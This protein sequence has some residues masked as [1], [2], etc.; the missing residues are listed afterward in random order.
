MI[1]NGNIDEGVQLLC[2]VGKSIDACKYLQ[3]Y[4]RYTDAAWL[5]K[6]SLSE[7][8]SADIMRRWANFLN[9]TNQKVIYHLSFYHLS[10]FHLSIH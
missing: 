10:F 4:D 6:I 1:A 5:A 2:L 7:S 3:S 9:V 8:E